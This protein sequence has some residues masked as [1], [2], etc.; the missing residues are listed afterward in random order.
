MEKLLLRISE[1]AEAVGLG[2]TK[3]YE[4]VQAGEVP[5]VRIGRSVRVSAEALHEW[6]QARTAEAD[7]ARR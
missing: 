6:V 2:K 1:A 5:S 3:F 7:D 4:L